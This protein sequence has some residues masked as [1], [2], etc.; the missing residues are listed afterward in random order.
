MRRRSTQCPA[1]VT[2]QVIGGRWKIPILWHLAQGT[3]RFSELQR[4]VG[5][6][7]QK[8]LTQQLREMER[9]GIVHRRVYPQVPPKVDE[10]PRPAPAGHGSGVAARRLP[11][12]R[13]ASSHRARDRAAGPGTRGLTRPGERRARRFTPGILP[14][15]M[16]TCRGAAS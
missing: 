3:K 10:A 15:L 16:P 2:L 9:D 4:A 8:M 11:S 5:G 7:T 14:R 1:E 13:L 12:V 6:I